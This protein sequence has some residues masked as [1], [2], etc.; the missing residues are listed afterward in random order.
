MP[1]AMMM[2]VPPYRPR[3]RRRF[4]VFPI[5]KPISLVKG[6]NIISPKPPPSPPPTRCVYMRLFRFYTCIYVCRQAASQA[7]SKNGGGDAS[8]AICSL[9]HTTTDNPQSSFPL[10]LSLVFVV[11]DYDY[12]PKVFSVPH[13][14]TSPPTTVT[15]SFICWRKK[16][17][18]PLRKETGKHF[19]GSGCF[20]WSA[21]RR[22]KWSVALQS[23]RMPEQRKHLCATCARFNSAP[24]L[25][26]DLFG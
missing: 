10:S 9:A 25:T 23:T 24:H 7:S 14:L 19:D 26:L 12:I 16:L 5:M 21:P 6:I 18:R 8:G 15:I 4:Q 22:T 2:K 1:C 11:V 20:C 17:C 13:A 3:R